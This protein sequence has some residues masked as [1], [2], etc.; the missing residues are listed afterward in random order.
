MKTFVLLQSCKI[1]KRFTSLC[2]VFGQFVI[3]RYDKI[4]SFAPNAGNSKRENPAKLHY[5][6]FANSSWARNPP[7]NQAAVE[8][9]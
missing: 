7:N 2:F 4:Y 6:K 3:L 5:K 1:F 8:K 9:Q